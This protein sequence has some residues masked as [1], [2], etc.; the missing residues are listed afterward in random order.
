M[1]QDLELEKIVEMLSQEFYGL[2][3]SL[4]VGQ[5]WE[6]KE[7]LISAALTSYGDYRAKEAQKKMFEAV[8]KLLT[9]DKEDLEIM[10]AMLT[11]TNPTK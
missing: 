7:S 8:E 3:D 6:E 2:A 4:I 11:P 9:I 1:T 10:S 5:G